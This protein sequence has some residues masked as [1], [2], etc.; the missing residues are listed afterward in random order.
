MVQPSNNKMFISQNIKIAANNYKF[1]FKN[2]FIHHSILI[3]KVCMVFELAPPPH[4]PSIFNLPRLLTSG[5]RVG[6][7]FD[8]ILMINI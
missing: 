7:S 1:S 8:D 3:L 4:Q 2:N 6:Y 5:C